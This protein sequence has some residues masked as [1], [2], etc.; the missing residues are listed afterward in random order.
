MEEYCPMYEPLDGDGSKSLQIVLEKLFP[1]VFNETQLQYDYSMNWPTAICRDC[2]QKVQDA[3]E[4][5][6]TCLDSSDRLHKKEFTKDKIHAE[7]PVLAPVDCIIDV[8]TE[9]EFVACELIPETDTKLLVPLTTSRRSMKAREK[10][11]KETVTSAKVSATVK[12]ENEDFS[13]GEEFPE[14]IS[15]EPDWEPPVPKARKATTAKNKTDKAPR[16]RKKPEQKVEG[17]TRKRGKGKKESQE[18]KTEVFVCQLCD[19]PTYESP[20]EL[21]DHLKAEHPAQIRSCDKCPKV[22]VSEQS[23]QHHQ[24]CHATGRSFFCTFCDKGFQ[25][26]MLLECH[27]RSHTR[28]TKCLCSI[29]GKSFANVSSLHMHMQLHDDTKS[30]PC[31]LCPCRFNTKGNVSAWVGSFAKRRWCLNCCFYLFHSKPQRSYAHSYEKQD[32]YVPDLWFTV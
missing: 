29:C 18:S 17:V 1:S 21:T 31:T 26:E 13:D 10:E 14:E 20:N 12:K 4:L 5:Y 7:V 9:E 30:F 3:Y 15:T 16:E 2:K 23:F 19:G 22:F 28:G 25:T 6:E 27:L 11:K 32:V 24:Y 8:P